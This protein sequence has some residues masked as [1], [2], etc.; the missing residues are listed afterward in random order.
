MPFINNSISNYLDT[1]IVMCENENCSINDLM[2][3][4]PLLGKNIETLN[5]MI[6]S[7]DDKMKPVEPVDKSKEEMDEIFKKNQ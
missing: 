6:K 2:K 5:E 4:I 1:Y 3:K 7:I